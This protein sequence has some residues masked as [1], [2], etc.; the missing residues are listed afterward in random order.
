MKLKYSKTIKEIRRELSEAVLA[1][2]DG[3]HNIAKA[4]LLRIKEI[5]ISRIQQG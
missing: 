3:A 4:C 2:K 5:V 1:D